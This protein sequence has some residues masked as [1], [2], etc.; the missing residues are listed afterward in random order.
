MNQNN[1]NPDN[2]RIQKQFQNALRL[3]KEE[4]IHWEKETIRRFIDDK[5]V[6]VIYRY[7]SDDFSFVFDV[8]HIPF[9]IAAYYLDKADLTGI[10]NGSQLENAIKMTNT[11]EDK[12]IPIKEETI[13]TKQTRKRKAK[14]SAKV[15]SAR[16]MT[17]EDIRRLS[18]KK[19]KE[20][21]SSKL[22]QRPYYMMDIYEVPRETVKIQYKDFLVRRSIFK[23]ANKDHKLKDIDAV[24]TFANT[25]SNQNSEFNKSF[26]AGYCEDCD[27]YFIME[28]TYQTIK[29]TGIPICRI[30]DEKSYLSG[31][32]LDATGL[33]KHSILMDYGYNVSQLNNVPSIQRKRIL[34]LLLEK[35]ILTKSEI[36]SYLDFFISQRQSLPQYKIAISSG[37]KTAIMSGISTRRT[38]PKSL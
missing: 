22:N 32:Y 15:L 17:S 30:T 38:L 2:K 7:K 31:E 33:A 28:S 21:S 1:S 3:T 19:E 4:R 13:S 20:K 6:E 26:H 16:K 18:S 8:K 12:Y 27:I 37:K 23:C 10:C 36:I 9:S 34:S 11:Y 35:G 29:N 5:H 24:I 14:K 25:D